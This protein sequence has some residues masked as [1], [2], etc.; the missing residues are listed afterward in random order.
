MI[1]T[2]R[3][4]IVGAGFS[5]IGAAIKLIQAGHTDLVILERNP[6]VGGTW[7][8]NTYPGCA[9]DVPSHLYSFSFAPNPAWTRRFAPQKEIGAYLRACVD[10]FGLRPYLRLGRE[11]REA[12][13]DGNRWNLRTADGEIQA[14]ILVLAQGPLSEPAVPDLLALEGF[15]GLVFHSARWRHDVDLRGKRVGVVGTGASAIQFVPHVQR[16]ARHVT[17]FQRTPAWI[18]PRGDFAIPAW[19][20]ALYRL[21]PPLQRLARLGEYLLREATLPAFLGNRL[22]AEAGRRKALRHLHRQIADP[23]L[24]AKL[25]PGYALGCK[26]VLASDDFYPALAQPNVD[27]VTEPITKAAAGELD[28][29][30]L[31]TGFR[32]SDAVHTR[33]VFG[34]DGRSLH[35]VWQGSP[36]AYLGTMVSGF[37]NLFLLAGPNTGVGH[38]SLIYMIESQ[39]AYLLDTL[40]VMR[41]RG[42]VEVLER[43]QKEYNAELDQAMGPTVWAAGGCSGWYRDLQGRITTIWPAPTWRFRRRTRRLDTDAVRLDR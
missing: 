41:R 42:T 28:V 14:E 11:L 15:D 12:S 32:V 16:V 13:W 34:R 21:A 17:L 39:L 19:L 22:M 37:P 4:A 36:Q 18:M 35:E 9:C 38:T 40:R 5:G 20:R 1:E 6:D 8:D 29:V 7:L 30:I 2:K 23:G 33:K 25:T 3:V 43:A 10:A 31:G 24:R 26:R 27:V